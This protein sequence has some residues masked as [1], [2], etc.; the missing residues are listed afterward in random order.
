MAFAPAE[1]GRSKVNTALHVSMV[2]DLINQKV[3]STV[4][5]DDA[6]VLVAFETQTP[7]SVGMKGPGIQSSSNTDSMNRRSKT[8]SNRRRR[9][10][11]FRQQSHLQEE[12]DLDFFTLHSS[13]VSHLYKDMPVNDIVYVK[14]GDTILR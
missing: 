11:N 9:K 4:N 2:R 8:S 13:V 14:P 6:K 1:F 7:E 3:T 5:D 12:P 10:H